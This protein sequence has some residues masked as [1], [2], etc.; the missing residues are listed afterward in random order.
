MDCADTRL[1]KVV[2]KCDKL[3]LLGMQCYL[4]KYL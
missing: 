4:L 3:D 2:I 1:I